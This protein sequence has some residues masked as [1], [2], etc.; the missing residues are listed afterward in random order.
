M[1]GRLPKWL[2]PTARRP[3][4][5]RRLGRKLADMGVHTVCQS[6]RCPNLGECFGDGRATFLILGDVCTRNC[7]FC[8]VDHGR[9]TAVDVSEPAR[10]A[11]AACMLDLQ[12]VVVTSVTRDDIEDGGAAQF[13]A[14]IRAI[15][16]RLPEATVEVLVPDFQGNWD[17]LEEVMDARP[18]VLN[19]NVET[20]ERLY[21]LVRPGADYR[22]SLELLRRVH[23]SGGDAVIKSGF[24]VGLGESGDEVSA[25]LRDLR[26]AAVEAVTIGQYLAP[27]KQHL[28][29]RE[30]VRP[31]TFEIYA[32]AAREL[33]F[34][35]ILSAPLVRSSYHAGELVGASST[36]AE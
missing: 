16:E 1:S 22:R 21:P 20:V 31:A 9:P 33:G 27:T 10:V 24:M 12:H 30:Y 7:A 14:A 23:S 17:A 35:R 3:P 32:E 11:D 19:H 29:I 36:G 13:A 34:R 5:L 8:A 2:V 26:A 25:L 28:P 4:E 15:R 6:A 18:D